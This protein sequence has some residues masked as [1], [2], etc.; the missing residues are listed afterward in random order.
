[1]SEVTTC[2]EKQ[3]LCDEML[4]KMNAYWRAAN[5]LSAGQLYLLD[6][7]LLREPL[8]MEHVKKKIV[9]HWGTVPGQNFV[10]THCNRVIKRYD[11]DMIYISGPGHGGNFQ[12]SNTYLE[13][14]YSEV[15][16]NISQD[17]EGMKKMFKQFS[18]PCGVP[19]HCAPETPGSINEGGELGYSIAHAF[20]AVFDNPELIA[21]AVVGDGEAETGPLATSW[22]SN[23]FLNPITDGAVLPIMNLN[24]YKISNP[25]L[26]ARMP[27]EEV[28][29][30]FKGCGWKA[31]FVEGDDPMTMHRK[32]AETMD[33][34]IEE[35]KAIQKNARENNNPERPV[36]PMIVLRTPKGWTGPKVVDGQQIEGT[37]R[38]HQVP[39][40]ME[41]PEHLDQLREWLLSYHPEELFDENGRIKEEIAELCPKGDA[42][43]GANPHANGGKLLKD[44][45]LPDFRDYGIEVVPGKT[46]AQDM[47]ELGGYVRDIFR[48]NEENKNFRIFGPDESM[49]NR[50][51]RA[52]EATDRDW[53]AGLVE[54]DDHLAR[55]GRI[56]D[57]M[58]SEHMC[59]GWLEGY[60]LTGR[61]GFFASYEAFIRIVDSMAAQH[62]KWLKVCNQLSWRQPIASLNFIL[63]SNVWQQDHNGFTHQDPGFLDHIANKKADVVRMYLPP[64]TN[65]LLSCF[66]HC[67]KSKNYVNAIVA[68]KHPS[69]QWLTMEQAVK[70]CTQGVSIWDWASNDAGEEPDVVLAA[71]GDTPTLEVMAAVT[72]L[73]DEM[74]DLKIRV[75]NVVDLFKLE[76]ESRHPH[77]LSDREY[78]A[79]F[80]K[81]KPVIFA[82]HGYPTLIHELTFERHNHNMSVH[83]YLEEGT[84]TTPFDMRVQNQIDRFN[85]VKDVIMHLPQLGNKGSHLI[86]KMNDKLIEHK[87]YIAEY[88]QDLE[89][90]RNWEWH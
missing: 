11:L 81:D 76:S 37:F 36:W 86:Q 75:I 90:V 50:L 42:R 88:G 21:V 51:Y 82:F 72:I 5:Y 70:H 33:V 71:C 26:F 69:C 8:T 15:Y 73:R 80:T 30:F 10:W 84:I 18:F 32:M 74:P 27:K 59:E 48:L 34:V 35:I 53:N 67:I 68:S 43:M 44:L 89:E 57:G 63:T 9:G 39:M 38:A 60:L 23:K 17:E 47:I 41:K 66:D 64:D 78:D 85:L 55:N 13:G 61:H 3:P 6:N 2:L 62:A 1:M 49:S 65:C 52:F 79:L 16:P 25:T 14:S 19:S 12:I 58:L 24:G 22:Q 87:Q 7:P 83:G 4:E 40:T 45:R 31:Y 46:K 56:M 77:G 29:A 54:N 28:E 20:G